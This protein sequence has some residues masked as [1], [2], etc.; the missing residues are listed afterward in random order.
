M[1]KFQVSKQ[2]NKQTK[3]LPQFCLEWKE[4]QSSDRSKEK[5]QNNICGPFRIVDRP[6]ADPRGP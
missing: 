1:N 6:L 5:N 4:M 3:T 2:Q